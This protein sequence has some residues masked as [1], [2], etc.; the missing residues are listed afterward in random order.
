VTNLLVQLI[1]WLNAAADALGRI[2]LAPIALAPGWLS[3]TVVSAVTGVLLLLVFKYTSN[4]RAIKRARDDINANLL[5]LKLFKE[6]TS[7]SLRAQGRILYGALRLFVLAIVPMLVMAV[8]VTLLLGQLA[9]WYQFRPLEVGEEA[10]VTLTLNG[11]GTDLSA[12]R[13]EPNPAGDVLIGPV[14]VPSKREVCWKIRARE[15]GT[16]RLVFAAGQA[17]ADKE[18][19][20]SPRFLRVSKLRPSW[21]WS[22][23][24]MNPAEAPFRPSSQ[25]RSIDISY[26]DRD[27]WTSGTDIW[28]FYWFAVSFVAAL[29]FRRALNVNI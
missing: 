22:D 14:R 29:L 9:L 21:Q 10:V 17:T 13:L 12:V 25:V 15:K 2:V 26:P 1:V 20:I 11:S 19:A 28:V 7:V 24:L 23:V 5:A 16:H 18:L 8:P 27:S 3:A 6:S 4:Q